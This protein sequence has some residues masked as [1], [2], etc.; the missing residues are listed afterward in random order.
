MIDLKWFANNKEIVKQAYQ[1]KG[2]TFNIDEILDLDAQKRGLQVKLDNLRTKRNAISEEVAKASPQGKA[3]LLDKARVIKEAT[4]MAEQ[5]YEK[6]AHSLHDLEIQLHNVP[7]ESAPTQE[8]G[9]RVEQVYGEPTKFDFTIKDH[10][11]LGESLDLIDVDRAAKVSGARFAFFKNEAVVLQF[12]LIRWVIDKLTKKGFTAMITPMLVKEEAMFG[13]G[14]F[15]AEPNEVFK[16][17]QD[18]LY[19]VGTAEVPLASYHAGETFQ[20]NDLPKRYAGYSSCFRREAGSY[21]K[22][23]YGIIR[24]HQF[25]KVEQ[26][27]YAH[28]SKSWEHFEELAKNSEEI[29]TELE[30]PFR[31]I[32]INAGELSAP[33]AKKYDFECWIPSQNTYRELASCSNDTDFQARRL[34]VRYKDKTGQTHF[35][36]TLNNTAIAIGRTIVAILENH[37]QKDGSVKMPKVLHEYLPFVVIQPR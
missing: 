11:E 34:N 32:T 12:A 17:A 9:D 35:V 15:P 24:Q 2:L 13:T 1:K 6:V 20:E 31:K 37:Q 25:D 10:L 21:G 26:F 27:I 28:P 4:Q 14:F 23:T 22:D 36:H 29:F 19:L 8:E 18:D 30:L 3:E 16:M 7:H 33:N 5:E